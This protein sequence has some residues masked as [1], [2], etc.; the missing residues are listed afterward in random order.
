LAQSRCLP[1]ISGNNSRLGLYVPGGGNRGRAARRPSQRAHIASVLAERGEWEDPRRRVSFDGTRLRRRRQYLGGEIFVGSAAEGFQRV[2]HPRSAALPGGNAAAHYPIQPAAGFLAQIEG[3][4][5]LTPPPFGFSGRYASSLEL[6]RRPSRHL[7]GATGLHRGRDRAPIRSRSFE[8]ELDFRPLLQAV[9]RDRLHGRNPAEIALA[10]SNAASARVCAMRHSQ[11]ARPT[12]STPSFSP[13]ACFRTNC[14]WKTFGSCLQ[15]NPCTSGPIASSRLTTA[16]LAWARQH[17]PRSAGLTEVLSAA[18][19][20]ATM[21]ELSI[22]MSIVEMAEEE[23]ECHGGQVC[24]VHS[25]T[26][27]VLGRRQRCPSL[28]LRDGLRRHAPQ[29]LALSVEEVPIVVFCIRCQAR[30]GLTSAQLFCCPECDQPTSIRHA[31]ARATAIL[32][33]KD[34]ARALVGAAYAAYRA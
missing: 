2:A 25:E 5:D 9:I 23:A 16:A 19:E 30:R 12:S 26:G 17:W 11:S 28:F 8:R 32:R 14:Y 18:D 3:R 7:A 21:H 4:P 33:G 20:R 10:P 1:C 31:K 34:A 24:A 27:G 13:A 6:V 29:G 15:A 22:A